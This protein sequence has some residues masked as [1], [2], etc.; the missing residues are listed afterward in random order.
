MLVEILVF[1]PEDQD[2]AQKLILAGLAEHWGYLDTSK[3]PDLKNIALSY[4]EGIFLVGK[5]DGVIVATGA[6]LHRADDT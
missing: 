4:A 2:A 6:F 5:L 1:S 3:N